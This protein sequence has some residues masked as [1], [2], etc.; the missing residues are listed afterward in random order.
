MVSIDYDHIMGAMYLPALWYDHNV[1]SNL[2]VLNTSYR[3]EI[4][5]KYHPTHSLRCYIHQIWCFYFSFWGGLLK[6]KPK[7]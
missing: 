4:P 3:A 6:T 2:K 5:I 7:Q 1:I